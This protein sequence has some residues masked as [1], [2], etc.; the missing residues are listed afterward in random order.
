PYTTLF[1]SRKEAF[2]V[3]AADGA[4]VRPVSQISEM[5]Q[6]FRG[7]LQARA[8]HVVFL[9]WGGYAGECQI[10]ASG[11]PAGQAADG[12]GVA[13]DP[14]SGAGV[15]E[16]P[17]GDLV[18][19]RP[20]HVLVVAEPGEYPV[21]DADPGGVPGQALVQADDHHPAPRRAFGVQLVELVG[22]LLGVGGRVEAG[23]VEAGDVVEVH[24]I[25]HRGERLPIDHLQER[26]V[27]G[28]VVNVVGEP[29][30]L[31]DL[32]GV[33]AGP[34]PVVVVPG[35]AGAGGLLD[36]LHAVGDPFFFLGTG[37]LVLPLPATAVR[38]GLMAAPYDLR[39]HFRVPADG[40]A[41]HER[42]HLDA[43][44]VEQVQ[45]PGHALAGPVLIEAVLS[46]IGKARQD[47]LGDRAASAADRLAAGLELHGY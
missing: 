30:L 41:D 17:L 8:F 15:V 16:D 7:V 32:Q 31:Q 33:D 25:R 28:Q 47:L 9:S 11:A 18:L 6:E 34:D 12:G 42:G 13:I 5:A 20:P 27:G 22:Q 43:V 24:R 40:V 37:Q 19:A 46:Q 36:R 14:G 45:D 26:L 10:L 4:A 1:R 44:G 21:Q 3:L 2:L 35:R 39:S 29:E 23:E 38:A